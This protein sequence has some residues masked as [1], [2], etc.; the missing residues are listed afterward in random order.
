ML[1]ESQQGQVGIV[2]DAKWYEPITN[3]GEDFDAAQR[4]MD[5]GLG[6]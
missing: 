4:A 3:D 6:W 5:F 2:L 1:Q